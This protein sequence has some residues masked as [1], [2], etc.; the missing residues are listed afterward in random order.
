MNC[1]RR[2][3]GFTRPSANYSF[4][5][6]SL[7]PPLIAVQNSYQKHCI[8][9][10]KSVHKSGTMEDMKKLMGDKLAEFQKSFESALADNTEA[11]Q[12]LLDQG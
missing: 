7:T 5:Q 1:I 8:H 3:V 11:M 2:L 4:L 6:S 9:T 10:S 12:G